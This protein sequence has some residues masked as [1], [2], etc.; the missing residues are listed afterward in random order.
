M[1]SYLDKVCF[2]AITTILIFSQTVALKFKKENSN[3][4]NKLV[5][6]HKPTSVLNK[7]NSNQQNSMMHAAFSPFDALTLN[8]QG[9]NMKFRSLDPSIVLKAPSS[10][11]NSEKV[12][13]HTDISKNIQVPQNKNVL[14]SSS[15]QTNK[16]P[17]VQ[18]ISQSFI[19][20]EDHHI[21][22]GEK[23]DIAD[24]HIQEERKEEDLEDLHLNSN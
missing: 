15:K 20:I 19:D 10:N 11:S 12:L 18:I 9:K 5:H 13:I 16:A 2:I 24:F 22:M 8:F 23:V 3:I 1:K 4:S 7:D 14:P 17:R 21:L 6:I